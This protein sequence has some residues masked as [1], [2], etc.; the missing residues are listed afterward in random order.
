MKAIFNGTTIAES[1]NT[2][3]I[4][5]NYYFPPQ[6]VKFDFLSETDTQ[7]TCPWK[8]KASYYSIKADGNEVKDAAWTYHDPKEKASAIKDHIAFWRGVEV[9]N[10]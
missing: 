3:L 6:D 2:V 7:T 4:E 9:V 1:N 5:G 10:S 8:G